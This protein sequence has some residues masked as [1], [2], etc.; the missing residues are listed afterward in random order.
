MTRKILLLSVRPKYAEKILA[1]TKKIELRRIKPRV[2]EGDLLIL[3]VSYPIKAIMGIG[4]VEQTVSDFPESLWKKVCDG[5]GISKT[6]FDAYYEG[7]NLGY[8]IILQ[9]VLPLENPISLNEL[10]KLWGN[11]HPPQSYKYLSQQEVILI[12]PP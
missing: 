2:S 9:K 12:S 6:E 8:G 10:R 11:F 1:G 4:I 7:A 5:A 3:Y